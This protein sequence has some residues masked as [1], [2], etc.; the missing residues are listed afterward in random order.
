[1][2]RSHSQK[3]VAPAPQEIPHVILTKISTFAIIETPL[4]LKFVGQL[5]PSHFRDFGKN[6][7]R[8]HF[9][10]FYQPIPPQECSGISVS[11]GMNQY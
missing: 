3:R 10:G 8:S 1:M 2:R 6:D 9:R 7:W 4:W 5:L 11:R